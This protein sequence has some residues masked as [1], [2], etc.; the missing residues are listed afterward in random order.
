MTEEA[1][2]QLAEAIDR[3]TGTFEPPPEMLT[4]EWDRSPHVTDCLRCRGGGC[5]ACNW[6]GEEGFQ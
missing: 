3:L 5:P 2:K 1:E 4:E 6:S